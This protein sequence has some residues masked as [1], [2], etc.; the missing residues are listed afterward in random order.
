MIAGFDENIRYHER[1]DLCKRIRKLG[2][3]VKFPTEVVTKHLEIECREG[4]RTDD[5]RNGRFFFKKHWG[6]PNIALRNF[7]HLV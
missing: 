1:Q 7:F 2:L 5:W 3:V 6:T 4:R